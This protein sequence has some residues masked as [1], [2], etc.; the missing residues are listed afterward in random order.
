M[1][2]LSRNGSQILYSKTQNMDLSMSNRSLKN[3]A[4]TSNSHHDP[5]SMLRVARPSMQITCGADTVRYSARNPQPQWAPEAGGVITL[6]KPRCLGCVCTLAHRGASCRPM[7]T[8]S[9]FAPALSAFCSGMWDSLSPNSVILREEVWLKG[10]VVDRTVSCPTAVEWES[11][12]WD[13]LL[14]IREAWTRMKGTHFT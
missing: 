7:Q 9:P 5:G 14:R 12:E 4:T 8:S 6:Q 13:I 10:L 2:P 11:C 3:H 1:I